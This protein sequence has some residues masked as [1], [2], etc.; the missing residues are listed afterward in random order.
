M[1]RVLP[2]LRNH[3]LELHLHLPAVFNAVVKLHILLNQELL[4][5]GREE[6]V[7]LTFYVL[8]RNNVVVF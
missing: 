2:L 7:Q 4:V 1:N 6:I 8:V 3:V 5:V